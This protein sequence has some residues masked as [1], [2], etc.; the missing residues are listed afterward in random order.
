MKKC[1][2]IGMLLLAV[3]LASCSLEEK[4]AKEETIEEQFAHTIFLFNRV[5]IPYWVTVYELPS[6]YRYV[7]DMTYEYARYSTKE[8]VADTGLEG[9]KIYT[10]GSN[11]PEYLYLELSEGYGLWGPILYGG[12]SSGEH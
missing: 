9:C 3:L 8:A 10:D 5:Y 12:A 1:R 6:G 7:D 11:S 2:L 4:T